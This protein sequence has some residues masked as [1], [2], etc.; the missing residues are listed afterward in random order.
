MN[1]IEKAIS[2]VQSGESDILEYILGQ[3]ELAGIYMKEMSDKDV[4]PTAKNAEE[5]LRQYE[6]ENLYQ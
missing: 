5:W 1:E 2:L 3:P 6:N 4:T